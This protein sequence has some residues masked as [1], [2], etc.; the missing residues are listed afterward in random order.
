MGGQV[1]KADD[2]RCDIAAA[3]RSLQGV[4][5]EIDECELRGRPC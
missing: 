5:I 4:E 2:T 3:L 1:V